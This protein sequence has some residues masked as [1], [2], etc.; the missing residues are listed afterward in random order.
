MRNLEPREMFR[1]LSTYA[2]NFTKH[3]EERNAS[4]AY[5]ATDRA[6]DAFFDNFGYDQMDAVL[7]MWD[8]VLWT[9]HWKYF[10]AREGLKLWQTERRYNWNLDGKGTLEFTGPELPG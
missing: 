2:R 6:V 8:A 10:E 5:A 7:A 3:R 4:S 1:I 9:T